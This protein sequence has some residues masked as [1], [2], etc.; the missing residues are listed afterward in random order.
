MAQR[1]KLRHATLF[2]HDYPLPSLLCDLGR[3]GAR[4]S[5]GARRTLGEQD[6]KACCAAR[7]AT[8]FAEL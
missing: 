5:W 3:T 2:Y 1:L 4:R 7:C 8:I 6:E